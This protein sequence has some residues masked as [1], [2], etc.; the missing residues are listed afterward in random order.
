MTRKSLVMRKVTVKSLSE[1]S[2]EE[3]IAKLTN[4]RFTRE[5]DFVLYLWN[6]SLAWYKNDS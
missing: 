4:S 2:W 1:V 5:I 6:S 3:H